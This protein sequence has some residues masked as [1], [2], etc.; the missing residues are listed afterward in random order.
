MNVKKISIRVYGIYF[1]ENRGLFVTDELID[2]KK[3]TKFP[4]GGLELGESTISALK[5][6][7]IE[8][9]NT[10]IEIIK[11]IHTTDFFQRSIF[12]P[13]VQV[14]C[15]YYQVK[16][17]SNLNINIKNNEFDFSEN[18][19]QIFRFIKDFSEQNLSLPTDK[20]AVI[21]FINYL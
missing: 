21:Q 10:E 4:G 13:E 18:E 6:E 8:E 12:N 19:N 3:I 5:R 11:H 14:I 20:K 1:D 7:W 9:L 16:P 2:N 15:V 17:I